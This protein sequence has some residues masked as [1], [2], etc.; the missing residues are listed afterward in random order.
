MANIKHEDAILKMGFEETVRNH[1][2][3]LEEMYKIGI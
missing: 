1:G 3:D 2:F